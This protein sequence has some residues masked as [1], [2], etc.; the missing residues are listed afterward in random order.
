MGIFSI[1]KCLLLSLMLKLLESASFNPFRNIFTG[2]SIR[3][4]DLERYLRLRCGPAHRQFNSNTFIT[5]YYTGFIRNPLTGN[6]IAGIEGVEFV[7]QYPSMV[8][9]ASNNTVFESDQRKHFEYSYLSK[10]F[11]A[12]TS[13]NNRSAILKE[14]RLRPISPKRAIKM[15]SK[16]YYELIHLSP[17]STSNSN[18]LTKLTA[19]LVNAATAAATSSANSKMSSN[20]ELP[21]KRYDLRITWPG[22]RESLSSKLFIQHG[23]TGALKKQYEVVNFVSGGKSSLESKP[24]KSPASFLRWITRWISFSGSPSDLHGRSQE[25]YSLIDYPS[26]IQSTKLFKNLR[27]F[28]SK[29]GSID[30]RSVATA[31]LSYRRYGES[32]AWYALRHSSSIEL[33]GYRL[34]DPSFLPQ[35]ILDILEEV[36]PAFLEEGLSLSMLDSKDDI[37]ARYRPW[38]SY[39]NPWYTNSNNKKHKVAA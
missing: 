5:W 32:P 28:L 33:T 3:D 37:L 12:Y 27:K 20:H 39:L 23:H 2:N 17:S 4:R 10:K 13:P 29:R 38:H 8:A 21:R 16:E 36:A 14:Y 18:L 6:E 22:R 30:P 34:P 24:R 15:P 31:S 7:K 11:F 26:R 19:P 1:W 25:Y 35:T 9:E